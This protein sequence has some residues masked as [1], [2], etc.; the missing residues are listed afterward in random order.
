MRKKLKIF[1]GLGI[2]GILF[3]VIA[4]IFIVITIPYIDSSAI[5]NQ[6]EINLFYHH[7]LKYEN[8]I[9]YCEETNNL[10]KIL[11]QMGLDESD[12]DYRDIVYDIID[13]KI[14]AIS[15]AYLMATN[16]VNVPTEKWKGMQQNELDQ[17]LYKYREEMIIRLNSLYDERVI[18]AESKTHFLISAIFFQIFGLIIINIIP[19]I[20]STWGKQT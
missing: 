5:S 20:Q 3:I 17:E 1:W 6:N 7:Y 13:C 11:K 8:A 19:I 18:I 12:V 16:D 9:N 2:V 10:L 4:T 14:H 15:L